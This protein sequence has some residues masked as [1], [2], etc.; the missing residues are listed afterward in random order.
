M[1]Q[2]RHTHTH[3][4]THTISLYI[5]HHVLWSSNLNNFQVV[6]S[7]NLSCCNCPHLYVCVCVCVCR[8]V[9]VCWCVCVCVLDCARVGCVYSSTTRTFVISW[10]YMAES[11]IPQTETIFDAQFLIN[12]RLIKFRPKNIFLS[13]WICV[14]IYS[15][16]LNLLGY[17]CIEVMT[18]NLKWW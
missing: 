1:H 17:E 8:C 18:G 4:H 5:I 14:C 15:Q 9:G 6:L 11:S 3:T 16:A 10:C 13:S 12:F 2:H 7:K